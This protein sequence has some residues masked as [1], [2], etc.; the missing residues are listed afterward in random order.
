[1]DDFNQSAQA[2]VWGQLEN[3]LFEDVDVADL[4]VTVLGGPVFADNDRL[5]RGV[6]LPRE[7]WKILV[8]AVGDELRAKAFLL[9]QNL[10][11]LESLDLDEFRVFQI[12][13]TDVEP[14]G[15]FHLPDVLHDADTA[16]GRVATAGIRPLEST[17]DIDWK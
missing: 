16:A 3:A 17:A 13:L 2:G 11:Q 8:F 14:R 12:P 4:K 9:T 10:E 1:M 6:R 5:F 15:R 7:F